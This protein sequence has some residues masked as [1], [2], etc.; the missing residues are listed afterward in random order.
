MLLFPFSQKENS[1]FDLCCY[2]TYVERQDIPVMPVVSCIKSVLN[3]L[4]AFMIPTIYKTIT[5]T[6]YTQFKSLNY[7]G[8]KKWVL[9]E[10]IIIDFSSSWNIYE[11]VFISYVVLMYCT[12][13]SIF[14]FNSRIWIICFN[15]LMALFDVMLRESEIVVIKFYY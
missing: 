6:T 11:W 10:T 2:F 13:D 4:S 1:M 9:L 3:K 8:K 5:P 14:F 12:I 7:K 15:W